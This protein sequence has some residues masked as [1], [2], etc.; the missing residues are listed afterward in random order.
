MS[1]LIV[2]FGFCLLV[3]LH[4]AG[5][6]FAAKATGMRVE[7]FFLFFGPTIC[8]V[9]AR[10]DR[11]RDHGDSAGGLRENQRHESRRGDAA[12]GRTPRLLPAA[13]MEADPC[14]REPAQR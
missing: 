1:W 9:Q 10:R 7:R 5:H 8:L 11:V 13:G 14:D 2:L 6:F 4:E 12:G 3:I